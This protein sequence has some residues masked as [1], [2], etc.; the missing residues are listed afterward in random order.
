MM[1]YLKKQIHRLSCHYG[2]HS[3]GVQVSD[4]DKKMITD[5]VNQKDVD[6]ILAFSLFASTSCKNCG[7][8]G[9]LST[10]IL[11][12]HLNEFVNRPKN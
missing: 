11:L 8:M 6:P 3:L 9:W 7:A 5:A 4:E 10:H 12:N 1:N 2:F